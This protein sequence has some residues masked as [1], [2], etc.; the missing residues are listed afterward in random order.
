MSA[1]PRL[2]ALLAGGSM[3]YVS[4]NNRKLRILSAYWMMRSGGGPLWNKWLLFATGTH[5]CLS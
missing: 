4:E 1:F 2:S 5:V 3:C